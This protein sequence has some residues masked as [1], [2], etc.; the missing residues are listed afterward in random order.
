M[1]K[2]FCLHRGTRGRY[3]Q[4]TFSAIVLI[5]AA[6]GTS[7]AMAKK[8]KQMISFFDQK[9]TQVENSV[10]AP[11]NNPDSGST[12]QL[13]DINLDF[14]GQASFGLSD[15]FKL[16]LSTEIDFVLVPDDR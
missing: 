2:Q 15:V 8:N 4:R 3:L 6:F 9:M 1:T 11:T 14:T 7:S 13:T 5:S 12:V 10:M 16:S